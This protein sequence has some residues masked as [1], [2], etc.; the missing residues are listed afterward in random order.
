MNA[1]L[2]GNERTIRFAKHRKRWLSLAPWYWAVINYLDSGDN[3]DR[4]YGG[5]T[6]L[7]VLDG[8]DSDIIRTA[9]SIND[10]RMEHGFP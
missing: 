8:I 1:Y 5:W 10:K 4:I 9:I 3:W 2:H 7:T 6:P